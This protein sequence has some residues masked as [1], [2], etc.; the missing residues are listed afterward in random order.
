MRACP[1]S[2]WHSHL[3]M[4]SNPSS[5]WL[6]LSLQSS[7][8]VV[9][10]CITKFTRSFI[11]RNL[12]CSCAQ[13]FTMSLSHISLW[14]ATRV[15]RFIVNC[16][17]H[18]VLVMSLLLMWRLSF[19]RV[20]SFIWPWML[21]SPRNR[22]ST[23]GHR[24]IMMSGGIN[25]CL[26]KNRDVNQSGSFRRVRHLWHNQVLGRVEYHLFVLQ[27]VSNHLLLMLQQIAQSPS[28]LRTI[29]S[30]YLCLFLLLLSTT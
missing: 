6:I 29:L 21:H 5:R 26:L 8:R 16:N 30:H 14:L 9:D 12:T 3:F 28:S 13:H 1:T 7:T 11:V 15:I 20:T 17:N 2:L 19:I 18:I 27:K 25:S 4:L 24:V 22:S 10:I 23:L